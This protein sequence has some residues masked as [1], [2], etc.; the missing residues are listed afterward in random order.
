MPT[1][2]IPNFASSDALARDATE[3]LCLRKAAISRLRLGTYSEVCWP[4]M[5]ALCTLRSRAKG[6]SVRIVASRANL[7]RNT[8]LRALVKLEARGFVSLSPD[9]EDRRAISVRLTAAGITAMENAALSVKA[10]TI[11]L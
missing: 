3:I 2:W 7:A 8:A 11:R 5:L 10:G 9:T 4:V 1:P 6:H